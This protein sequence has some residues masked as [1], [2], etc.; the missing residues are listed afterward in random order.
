MR[1]GRSPALAA[2]ALVLSALA[3]CGWGSG[4]TPTT[5]QAPSPDRPPVTCMARAA[6]EC[7]LARPETPREAVTAHAKCAEA[8]QGCHEEAL[9]WRARQDEIDALADEKGE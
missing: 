1:M 4:D 2:G 8:W 7:P 9:K 3:G 6:D 5:I